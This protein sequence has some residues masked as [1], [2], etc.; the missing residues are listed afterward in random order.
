ML[1]NPER[2]TFDPCPILSGVCGV[3]EPALSFAEGTPVS[4]L[5]TRAEF[6]QSVVTREEVGSIKAITP[7]ASTDAAIASIPPAK[8]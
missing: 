8:L 3:E 6:D 7:A 2:R 1:R 4:T 5:L